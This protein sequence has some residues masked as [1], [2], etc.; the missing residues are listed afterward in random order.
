MGITN[1]VAPMDMEKPA[2]VPGSEQSSRI[3]AFGHNPAAG[4]T[5]GGAKPSGLI[6]RCG[7]V[8][9][10]SVHQLFYNLG[11]L[12]ARRPWAVI[13]T[14]VLVTLLCGAVRPPPFQVHRSGRTKSSSCLATRAM[15]SDSNSPQPP[16]TCKPSH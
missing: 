12:V 10:H 11:S 2:S 3:G 6:G 7:G 14:C 4:G 8:V 1:A 9:S 5:V 13:L 15:L 16:P